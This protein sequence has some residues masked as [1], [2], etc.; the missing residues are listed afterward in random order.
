MGS[1]LGSD[2]WG[3]SENNEAD[4]EYVEG[5]TKGVKRRAVL[6]LMGKEGHEDEVGVEDAGEEGRGRKTVGA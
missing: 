1:E 6:K 4:E 5:W 2:E 3:E